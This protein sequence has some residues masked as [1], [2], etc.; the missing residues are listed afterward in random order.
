MTANSRSI[1]LVGT[2]QSLRRL[3]DRA[4][5]VMEELKAA[6]LEQERFDSDQGVF[7]EANIAAI[8]SGEEPLAITDMRIQLFQVLANS[9]KEIRLRSMKDIEDRIPPFLTSILTDP[10]WQSRRLVFNHIFGTVPAFIHFA[11]PKEGM[12][13][14]WRRMWWTQREFGGK[15]PAELMMA[16]MQS[17][18]DPES[19][20]FGARL[21]NNTWIDWETLCGEHIGSILT[22]D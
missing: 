22:S 7:A 10:V 13:I 3:Y 16:R 5:I 14:W 20:G 21:A 11:G 4:F 9:Y 17:S 2:R 18:T 19:H 12:E 1:A 8:K 6:L 15:S